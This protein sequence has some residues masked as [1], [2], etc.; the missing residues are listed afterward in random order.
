MR[1]HT[2][3]GW[4]KVPRSRD[5]GTLSR[6]S[7]ST[8]S[9][10]DNLPQQNHNSALESSEGAISMKR[11][12][13]SLLLLLFASCTLSWAQSR[14]DFPVVVK[15]VKLVGQSQE[16]PTTTIFTPKSTGL[17]RISLVGAETVAGHS[18]GEWQ[19]TVNWTGIVSR[20]VIG[21]GL[22]TSATLESGAASP[23]VTLRA[24]KPVKLRVGAIGDVTG[25]VYDI[26]IVIE[27]LT[28]IPSF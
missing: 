20:D 15:R 4:P 28:K 2:R 6:L 22:N 5:A 9:L 23:P 25:A 19:I 24:G 7:E 13:I 10:I 26:F 12:V 27:R 8:Q 21:F 18:G 17:F 16:I 11:V 14:S 1:R 3:C